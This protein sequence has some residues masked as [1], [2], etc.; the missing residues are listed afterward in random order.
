MSFSA[1]RYT[2]K[3]KEIAREK[4]RVLFMWEMDKRFVED[5]NDRSMIQVCGTM[6]RERARR[7][8][9]IIEARD[10]KEG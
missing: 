9:E 3:Q 7:I 6:S 8:W 1:K 4:K 5:V 10:P 2:P